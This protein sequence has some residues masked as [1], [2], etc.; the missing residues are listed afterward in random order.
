[1]QLSLPLV[2]FPRTVREPADSNR[3]GLLP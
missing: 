1:M 3:R 2:I